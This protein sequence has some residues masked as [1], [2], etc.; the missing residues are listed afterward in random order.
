MA[1]IFSY[2]VYVCALDLR[3]CD[4][5]IGQ[6]HAVVGTD[7]TNVRQALIAVEEE[8][9]A[10]MLQLLRVLC[11]HESKSFLFIL[12][13]LILSS[14]Q[15]VL[16]PF[17]APPRNILRSEKF[18]LP[19]NQVSLFLDKVL[20]DSLAD[21]LQLSEGFVLCHVVLEVPTQVDLE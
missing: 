1:T 16:R 12:Y 14:Y 9:L 21:D 20:L 8:F 5:V 7:S 3:H 15:I 18:L 19:L 6:Q 11:K 10:E 2:L 13:E 4:E 17:E